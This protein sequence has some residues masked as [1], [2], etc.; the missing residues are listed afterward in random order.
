MEFLLPPGYGPVNVRHEIP[1]VYASY[2]MPAAAPYYVEGNFGHYLTQRV[3]AAK[4]ALQLNLF[5]M[6]SDF[7]L[8]PYS[9]QPV[10]PLH[11][12]LEGNICCELMGFGEAWLHEGIYNLFFVPGSIRHH[13][14]FT[15]GFY[16]SFHV[17]LSPLYLPEL[18]AEYPELQEVLNRFYHGSAAGIQQHNAY[19]NPWM[20]SL[21]GRIITEC[22]A[23]QPNL[24]LYL[25]TMAFRL[26]LLYVQDDPGE[27]KLPPGAGQLMEEVKT[28]I[29]LRLD[30]QLTAASLASKFY[31]T[32][33]TLRRQFL[34]YTGEPVRHFIIK[35]RMA[36]AGKLLES[37]M[38][39]GD[40]ADKTG[41]KNVSGFT[42]AFTQFFGYPPSR[43]KKY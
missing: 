35:A 28:D 8:D 3:V 2:C 9:R 41:Y 23:T 33:S 14:S 32:E 19:I 16:R 38:A 6:L 34:Q 37:G 12:M 43:H 4:A 30:E 18:A 21:I 25:R 5:R 36:W 1:A 39:V 13:A 20:E 11:F 27:E 22:P 10:Q 29:L 40:V 15:P 31:L 24:G 26:L 17:D 42:R 7:T